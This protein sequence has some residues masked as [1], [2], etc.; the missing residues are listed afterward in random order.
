[1]GHSVEGKVAGKGRERNKNVRKGEN[2]EVFLR[3]LV[4]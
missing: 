4:E 3:T 2:V 1:L